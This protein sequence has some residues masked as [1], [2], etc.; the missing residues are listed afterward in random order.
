MHL[1]NQNED[2]RVLDFGFNVDTFCGANRQ[3]NSWESDWIDF[4]AEN[5][6]KFQQSLVKK[7]YGDNVLCDLLDKVRNRMPSLFDDI[8]VQPSL[9]HGDLWSGNYGSIN[10][11]GKKVPVIFDPASYFGHDEAELSIMSMFGDPGRSFWQAYH[12]LIPQ[13][14]GFQDRQMLYQLYHYLNHYTLFGGGYQNQCIHLCERI[15]SHTHES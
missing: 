6:L 1:C 2:N 8:K 4:F 3:D 9:L 13:R 5:R 14:K 11:E 10:L 15:I 12:Q 7:L